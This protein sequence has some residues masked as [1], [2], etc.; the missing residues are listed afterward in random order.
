MF[1]RTF[2]SVTHKIIYNKICK[3]DQVNKGKNEEPSNKG[4]RTFRKNHHIVSL[5]LMKRIRKLQVKEENVRTMIN[6]LR[7]VDHW[8]IF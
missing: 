7:K 3:T 2:I 1:S 5:K 8:E 4:N 6:H